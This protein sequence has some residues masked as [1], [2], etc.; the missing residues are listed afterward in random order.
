MPQKGKKFKGLKFIFFLLLVV[1]AVFILP[2]GMV[3]AATVP[4]A[5]TNLREVFFSASELDF[6]WTAPASDGGS[7]ITGYK[8][9]QASDTSLSTW[10]LV[11]FTGNNTTYQRNFIGQ[12]DTTYNFRVSAINAIGTGSPSGYSGIKI[13]TPFAPASLTASAGYGQITLNWSAA[14]SNGGAPIRNYKV[15]RSTTSGTETLFATLGNVLTYTD[16]GLT[17]GTTY[18]YKVLA[19]DGHGEGALSHEAQAVVL[20]DTAPP[21][22][23]ARPMCG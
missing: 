8:I 15:Y 17:G 14:D 18:Y 10:Y 21:T 1:S 13:W 19:A 22:T 12:A 11:A 7:A 4:G 6:S 20:A 23:M 2:R 3:Y 9:E 16:A 5:P